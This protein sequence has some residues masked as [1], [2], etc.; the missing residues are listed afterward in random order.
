MKPRVAGKPSK[1]FDVLVR[2]LHKLS[3]VGNV[4][5]ACLSKRTTAFRGLP[6]YASK[7]L[8]QALFVLG[9]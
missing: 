8:V 3:T 7:L 1:M 4:R 6:I 5:S 9:G 2:S